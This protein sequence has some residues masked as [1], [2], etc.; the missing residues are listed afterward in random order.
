MLTFLLLLLL[1]VLIKLFPK[2][3]TDLPLNNQL[4]LLEVDGLQGKAYCLPG[5]Q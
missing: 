3:V 2:Y 4:H 1:A 5:T